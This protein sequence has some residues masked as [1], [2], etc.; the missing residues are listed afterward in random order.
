MKKTIIS[1]CIILLVWGF[2]LQGNTAMKSSKTS[3]TVEYENIEVTIEKGVNVLQENFENVLVSQ[4]N[5]NHKKVIKQMNEAI[6]KK[7]LVKQINDTTLSGGG[8]TTTKEETQDKTLEKLQQDKLNY[9]MKCLEEQ[10][11]RRQ[12]VWKI[13]VWL[14]IRHSPMKGCGEYYVREQERTGIPAT[15]SVGIAEAESSSGKKCFAPYNAWGMIAPKY[16]KG[17]ASWEEGIRANFD[18]LVHYYGCPQNMC[19]C[20]GYCEGN[21][22][23]KTVNAVM[24]EIASIDA[25]HIR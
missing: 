13:D 15:L 22:T 1:I 8:S 16:R 11:A 10:R 14:D 18:W 9:I 24:A 19:D 3:K 25:S 21:G 23:M 4:L 12:L 6:A 7:N 2:L 5:R 17:F 20:P